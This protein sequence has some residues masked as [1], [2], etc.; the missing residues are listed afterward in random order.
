MVFIDPTDSSIDDVHRALEQVAENSH[1]GIAIIGSDYR[2]DYVNDRICDLLGRPRK[3]ILGENFLSFV[4]QDSS[5][6][7]LERYSKRVHGVTIDSDY[8]I[9]ILHA[10]GEPRNVHVRTSV[11]RDSGEGVK[12]LAQVLD[13]TDQKQALKALC[14]REA[15][16][17]TL[18]N[19]MNEG[20][21]VIDDTGTIVYANVALCKMLGSCE[22]EIVGRAAGDIMQGPDL[23]A[24]SDKI[25]DRIAGK[26]ERYE[27]KL[28]HTSGALLQVTVSAS[29]VFSE[30]GEYVGSCAVFTDTTEQNL[31]KK[32]LETARDRAVLYLDLMRHDIRNHLQEVQFAAEMIEFRSGDRSLGE[33]A[34]DIRDA[35]RRSTKVIADSRTIEQLEDVPLQRRMLDEILHEMMKDAS[36]LL[37]NV[38]ISL[39]LHVTDVSVMADEYLEVMLSDL[40]TFAYNRS[41]KR[42]RKIWVELDEALDLYELRITDD[43][44]GLSSDMMDHPLD[45]SLR[46][47]G[48]SLHLAH[49]IVRKYGGN[50][51]LYNADQTDECRGTTIRVT[52]PRWR[53]DSSPM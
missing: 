15:T 9:R 28:V 16:F 30:C 26:C 48:V 18:V 27:T 23:D 7:V 43:G 35:V 49:H 42:I 52:I 45:H 34:A 41:R 36:V 6:I 29:P 38:E 12:I 22:S 33:M 44:P 20:L 19:T 50:L 2:I 3:E 37:D 51:E 31:T 39:S 13:I 11:L 1:E 25:R 5:E 24:V 14:E 10:E 8:E 4:H 46:L 21:G 17:Q 32:R 47:E 40:L 53:Q